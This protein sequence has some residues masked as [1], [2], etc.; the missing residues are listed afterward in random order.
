M[1]ADGTLNARMEVRLPFKLK[2]DVQALS[3]KLCVSPSVVA[4]W[5]LRWAVSAP[6]SELLEWSAPREVVQE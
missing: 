3:R 4:R 6:R 5:A 1:V 2:Q